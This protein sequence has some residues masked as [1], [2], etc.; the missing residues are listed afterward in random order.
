MRPR[1]A[2]RYYDAN[3]Q[4]S[5]AWDVDLVSGYPWAAPPAGWSMAG[6]LRWL[7]GQLRTDRPDVVICYGRARS[8]A[9]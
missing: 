5:V 4:R 6:R 2:E 3:F 7:V 9:P 8:P 1:L